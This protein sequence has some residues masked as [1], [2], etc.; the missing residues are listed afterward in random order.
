LAIAHH[1][2]VLFF[3]K[4]LVNTSY[5]DGF[6]KKYTHFLLQNSLFE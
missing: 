4:Y 3:F 6:V 2:K 1:Y 5:Y